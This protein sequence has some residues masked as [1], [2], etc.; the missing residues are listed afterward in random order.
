MLNLKVKMW[1]EIATTAFD[2]V[3]KHLRFDKS[4]FHYTNANSFCAICQS[5]S[6]RLTDYRYLN[7]PSEYRYAV[8]VITEYVTDRI[9]KPRSHYKDIL[10]VVNNLFTKPPRAN[11]FVFSLSVSESSLGCWRAYGNDGHGFAIGIDRP[12]HLRAEW[13]KAELHVGLGKVVYAEKEQ[14]DLIN[15]IIKA[16]FNVIRNADKLSKMDRAVVGQMLHIQLLLAAPFIKHHTYSD[17]KE[18]RYVF[19]QHQD[20]KSIPIEVGAF[21]TGLRPYVTLDLPTTYV[22]SVT[23]GP[24]Q[25]HNEQAHPVKLMLPNTDWRQCIIPYRS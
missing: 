15:S 17:E 25:Q 18:V 23:G 12:Q 14:R 10:K 21:G 7:D 20:E 8:E 2:V 9:Q 13:S 6:I 1:D 11:F 22:H 16:V 19:W 24:C 3:E 4:I 5:A